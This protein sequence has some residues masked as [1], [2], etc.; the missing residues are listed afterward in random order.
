MT[1]PDGRTLAW[2]E[3]GDPRGTPCLGITGT[4]CSGIGQRLV[5]QP[6]RQA[7]VRWIAVDKPGYGRSSPDPDRSLARFSADV[8]ELLDHLG[9]ER[10]AV[11]GESGGGPHVLALAHDLPDRVTVALSVSGL[12]PTDEPWGRDG[13]VRANRVMFALA[14]RAPVVLRLSLAA[15][16][17]T[18]F[19][20]EASYAA[21]MLR[22]LPPADRAVLSGR[23][24]VRRV[25]FESTAD[26]LRQGSR[27]A[28][29]E[30]TMFSRPWH[31]DL[32]DIR[33]PVVLWHGTEDLN[34]PFTVAQEV[35]RRIPGSRLHVWEGEGH[36]ALYAHL[37][38]IL[39]PVVEAGR[40][41]HEDG[42]APRSPDPAGADG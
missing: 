18:A 41:P 27:G 42:V 29:Q 28:A 10:T 4:P 7:G 34:V 16:G 12:G 13:M 33:V 38:E 25:L 26:G 35:S 19:R 5:D 6:A 24:D 23:T 21:S 22:S 20:S 9:I 2:Y 17:R 31:F 1:L 3:F 40:P 30:F 32:A 11:Q 14:G 15:M 37:E 36:L 39:D 8:R